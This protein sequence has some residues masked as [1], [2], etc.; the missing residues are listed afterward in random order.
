MRNDVTRALREHWG[1]GPFLSHRSF[2]NDVQC[3]NEKYILFILVINFWQ[4]FVVR[5]LSKYQFEE[6]TKDVEF[7]ISSMH[8]NLPFFFF[9]CVSFSNGLF[10]ICYYLIIWCSDEIY[11]SSEIGS[12]KKSYKF[13]KEG[14]KNK[15][16]CSFIE[17]NCW[18][19][20]RIVNIF[21]RTIHFFRVDIFK[22]FLKKKMWD[23][24]INN[25]ILE[26]VVR[27]DRI[28]CEIWYDECKIFRH[29]NFFLFK[30]LI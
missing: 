29:P 4:R 16:K 12:F 26:L 5:S 20:F 2:S 25:F 19:K 15:F 14:S 10:S 1:R 24:K 22:K 13:Y 9:V 6:N 30:L 18:R 28:I 11:F 7:F 17:K 27:L 21:Y 3:I 23:I 8:F